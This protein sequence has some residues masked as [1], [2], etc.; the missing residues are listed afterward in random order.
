MDDELAR[1]QA[2][3]ARGQLPDADCLV[4]WYHPGRGQRCAVCHQRI[5]SVELGIQCDLPDGTTIWFHI[6]CHTKWQD[7][8]GR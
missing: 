2:N 7:A 5:L 3:I 1:I 8:V 6:P 4:T